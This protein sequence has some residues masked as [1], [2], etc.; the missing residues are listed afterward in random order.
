MLTRQGGGSQITELLSAYQDGS[1]GSRSG[2]G[3]G[4]RSG[5]GIKVSGASGDV[6]LRCRVSP[7]TLQLFSTQTPFISP[8][9]N[10]TT[11]VVFML[12]PST[13]QLP[14]NTPR[15]RLLYNDE[16][17]F[18]WL[19]RSGV[20]C[21]GRYVDVLTRE[22]QPQAHNWSQ[23]NSYASISGIIIMQLITARMQSRRRKP[24]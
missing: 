19:R 12:P 7:L 1:S 2:C 6:G 3:G 11:H 21:E 24:A 9:L 17:R 5:S 13:L 14:S 4:N 22:T 8:I 16:K 23:K 18:P 20:A 15:I 10:V